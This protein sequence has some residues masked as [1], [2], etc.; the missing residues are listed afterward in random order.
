VHRDAALAADA[1][2]APDPIADWYQGGPFCSD[3]YDGDGY[4]AEK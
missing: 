1:G 2:R 3:E 4:L